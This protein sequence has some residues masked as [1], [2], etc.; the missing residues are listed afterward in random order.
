MK[1][2]FIC[3]SYS[4][5]SASPAFRTTYIAKALEN[6]E[7]EV[8]ILT[9]DEQFQTRLDKYDETLKLNE[10]NNV[11]RISQPISKGK[12]KN[13][14]LKKILYKYGLGS[15]LIPDPHIK[16][17]NKFYEK[18]K[19]L[20]SNNKIDLVITFSFPHSFHLIGYRLN[21]ALNVNWMADY[22]DIWYGAPH[23]EFNKNWFFKKIDFYLEKKILKRAHAVSLTTAASIDFYKKYFSVK[24]YILTEMGH[25]EDKN[26]LTNDRNSTS[27]IVFLHAGR[28]YHPMRNPIK[29]ID[30]IEKN[31]DKLNAKLI[32]VGEIDEYLK[33]KFDVIN[34]LKTELISWMSSVE[35]QEYFKKADVLVLF[36]NQSSLQ[37]PGK[38]YEYLSLRKPILYLHL[39]LENDPILQIMKNF[40]YVFPVSNNNLEMKLLTTM[41]KIEAILKQNIPSNY[42][43]Y[44]SWN[45]IANRMIL[46]LKKIDEK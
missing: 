4:P 40:N 33:N 2:L 38:L 1:I 10:V 18:A 15:I 16:N 23:A 37:V 6:L 19:E 36:G 39:D 26:I 46:Q 32:L 29:M 28:L 44:Y 7:Q 14:L 30:F 22:G 35:L 3:A 31:S 34:P 8:F 11:T 41:E 25:I 5:R 17:V 45:Q 21:K 9:Y 12:S 27:E 20:I 42:D 43:N 13:L 24:N